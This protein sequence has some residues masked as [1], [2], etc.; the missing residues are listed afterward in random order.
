M[1]ATALAAVQRNLEAEKAAAIESNGGLEA[2]LAA[3]RREKDEV[4][5]RLEGAVASLAQAKTEQER[6]YAETSNLKRD[7]AA[8]QRA[9]EDSQEAG[10][11]AAARGASEAQWVGC[12]S[13][14]ASSSTSIGMLQ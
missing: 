11:R 14:M 5:G 12:G 2:D 4:V 9:A 3:A 7:L 13:H 8:S 6:L 10:R 1:A